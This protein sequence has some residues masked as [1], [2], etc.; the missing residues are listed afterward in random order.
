MYG[1]LYIVKVFILFMMVFKYSGIIY[2]YN[3]LLIAYKYF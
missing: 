2:T 3:K 1:V